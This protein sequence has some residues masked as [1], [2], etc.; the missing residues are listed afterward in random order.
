MSGERQLLA[1]P[2]TRRKIAGA[3]QDVQLEL[4]PGVGA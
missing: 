2:L 3:A 1:E 4:G